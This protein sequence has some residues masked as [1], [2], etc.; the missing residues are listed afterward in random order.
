MMSRPG[1][2]TL[3]GNALQQHPGNNSINAPIKLRLT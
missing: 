3:A 2:E 1:V